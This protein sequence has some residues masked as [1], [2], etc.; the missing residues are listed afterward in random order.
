LPEPTS[1]SWLP[2]LTNGAGPRYRAI[3]DA[4]ATDIASGRL[5]PGQRLPPQ[6]ALADALGVTVGTV[7]RAY[8]EAER[9]GLL[10]ATVGRGSFVRDH[11]AAMT[12][13]TWVSPAPA[14]GGGLTLY[15]P[16]QVRSSTRRVSPGATS[17]DRTAVRPPWV[18]CT[19]TMSSAVAVRPKRASQRAPAARCSSRP[20][21]G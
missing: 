1:P 7:T 5:L 20:T 18:P 8:A 10:D 9:R 15:D 21:D 16:G 13:R 11:S 2:D 12:A 17:V 14:A 6:R 19:G 3:A 4:L